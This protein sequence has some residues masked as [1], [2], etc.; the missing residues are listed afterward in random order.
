MILGM[1][2]C[3]ERMKQLSE[4][5]F[6]EHEKLHKDLQT[7]LCR[8]LKLDP[9]LF[10]DYQQ[11]NQLYN[12]IYPIDRTVAFMINP[13]VYEDLKDNNYINPYQIWIQ[14]LVNSLALLHDYE[15]WRLEWTRDIYKKKNNCSCLAPCYCYIDN[16]EEIM[17]KMICR[18][19]FFNNYH[20]VHQIPPWSYWF[21][22]AG[23]S[24]SLL[25]FFV[26]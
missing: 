7:F 25:K 22:K 26:I 6:T 23:S 20:H 11:L 15:S 2:S 17:Y 24:F 3:Y 21:N 16:M 4:L 1:R 14:N 10:A 19:V 18:N 5:R 9:T 13:V 8:V 12:R